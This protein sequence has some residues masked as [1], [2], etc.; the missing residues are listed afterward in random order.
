MSFAATDYPSGALTGSGTHNVT[1]SG[2]A[3]PDGMLL[4]ASLGGTETVGELFT[5]SIKL[6]TPDILNWA[7]FPPQPT[8]SSN[9]WW[10]KIC[11][12]ISNWMAAENVISAGW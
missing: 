5:Y 4:F 6:K 12:S 2:S 11:A 10:A 1:L 7:M 9:R 8:C 3:V